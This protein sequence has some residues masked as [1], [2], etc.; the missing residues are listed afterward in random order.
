M[1]FFWGGVVSVIGG[2]WLRWELS[3]ECLCLVVIFVG[4]FG[5]LLSNNFGFCI[6]VFLIEFG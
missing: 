1:G 6:G 5:L 2:W 4:W 3:I